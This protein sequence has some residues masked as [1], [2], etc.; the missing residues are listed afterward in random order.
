MET[1]VIQAIAGVILM[2][3]RFTGKPAVHVGRFRLRPITRSGQCVIFGTIGAAV[4]IPAIL[5]IASRYYGLPKMQHI[6]SALNTDASL[7]M[8]VVGGILLYISVAT[9]TLSG[10]NPLL[11][12]SFKICAFVAGM[13]EVIQNAYLIALRIAS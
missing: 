9:K 13:I 6:G 12:K 8:I 5:L 7:V 3:V 4:A 2:L 1:I 11:L 10:G